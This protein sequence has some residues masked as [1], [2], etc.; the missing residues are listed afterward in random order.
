MSSSVIESDRGSEPKIPSLDLALNVAG[1]FELE[2]VQAREIAMGVG[3]T[4]SGWRSVA[5]RLGLA[6]SEIDRMAT[7]FEHDDLKAALAL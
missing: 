4:V 5:A 6:T 7:A 2:D 1:Y 3:R